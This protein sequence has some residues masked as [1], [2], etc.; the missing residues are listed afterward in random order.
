MKVTPSFLSLSFNSS[1]H[2]SLWVHS[3]HTRLIGVLGCGSP[4]LPPPLL[5]GRRCT[6]LRLICK[7]MKIDGEIGS[8]DECE[9]KLEPGAVLGR[10]KRSGC[11]Q[12]NEDGE[13]QDHSVCKS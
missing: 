8:W 10:E 11:M 6:T 2:I 9:G 3:S 5:D 12:R 4:P 13:L 1:T 7:L